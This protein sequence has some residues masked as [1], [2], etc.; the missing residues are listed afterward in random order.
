MLRMLF[1]LSLL[2]K[3]AEALG[4]IPGALVDLGGACQA[5]ANPYGTQFFH[6]HI[7][8]HQKVPASEVH[9]PPN[10]CTPPYRKSWIRH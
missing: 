10:G 1:I 9:T 4:Q 5:H 6:F 7:H 3:F 2:F 8:F